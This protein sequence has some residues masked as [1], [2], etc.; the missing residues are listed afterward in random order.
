MKM[1]EKPIEKLAELVR[2]GRL[3]PWEVDVGKLLSVYSKK[4]DGKKW[5]DVRVPAKILYSAAFLLKMK[6]KSAINGNGKKIEEATDEIFELLDEL[7]DLGEITLIRLAPRRILLPE[8]LDLLKEALTEIP[9]EKQ[10]EARPEVRRWGMEDFKAIEDSDA[11]LAEKIPA[12]YQRIKEVLGAS[13][14][15]TFT[16]LLTVKTKEEILW[17]FISLLFLC[18]E[19]MIK[20]IQEEPFG[21]IKIELAGGK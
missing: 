9:L 10:A 2:D 7:P 17:V 21:E 8:L 11:T 6:S 15:A 16:D 5:N 3:D 13:G 14:L 18:T 20:M 12:V 4:I 1:L 19:G